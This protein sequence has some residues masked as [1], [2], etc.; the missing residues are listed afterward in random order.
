LIFAYFLAAFYFSLIVHELGHVVFA[1]A[2]NV[3]IRCVQLG[4]LLFVS[5]GKKTSA[6]L[7]SHILKGC[8]LCDYSDIDIGSRGL[9]VIAKKI[10][11]ILL[12]GSLGNILMIVASVLL[13]AFTEFASELFQ[14]VLLI[15]A[16]ILLGAFLE[17][18]DLYMRTAIS[19]NAKEAIPYL[20]EELVIG[21][22]PSG[23]L[24]GLVK[25]YVLLNIISHNYSARLFYLIVILL[26]YNYINGISSNDVVK[27]FGEL[28]NTKNEMSYSAKLYYGL[29]LIEMRQL[30][31][32][33][34]DYGEEKLVP[35]ILT[36]TSF[37]HPM[38]Y[39]YR[40]FDTFSPFM[41]LSG[42]LV[43][44]V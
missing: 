44:Y 34:A 1:V 42:Q 2:S 7:S 36:K 16:V 17:N 19:R 14:F 13:L 5:Y 32:D 43:D 4:F 20:A 18:Q 8:V 3:P 12:G 31:I 23:Y 24:Y 37:K 35:G 25:E 9:S 6:K 10:K 30:R 15:N 40:Y 11:L 22:S 21:G 33:G 26:R 28:Q 29:L 27:H 41:A 39:I 38:S